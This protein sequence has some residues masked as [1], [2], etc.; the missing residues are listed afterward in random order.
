MRRNNKF[1]SFRGGRVFKK[2]ICTM[3][4]DISL[5]LLR[6]PFSGKVLQTQTFSG[7]EDVDVSSFP[8]GVYYLRNDLT[9]VKQKV[10]IANNAQNLKKKLS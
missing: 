9:G 7:E 3:R 1:F 5:Q 4:Y 6:S 2:K 8:P 10:T